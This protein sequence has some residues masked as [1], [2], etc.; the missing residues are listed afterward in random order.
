M[1]ITKV[2]TAVKNQLFM[3]KKIKFKTKKKY[4]MCNRAVLLIRKINYNTY[5][6]IN[7]LFL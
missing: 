4:E 7:I 5:N 6:L 2:L 3:V 1:V